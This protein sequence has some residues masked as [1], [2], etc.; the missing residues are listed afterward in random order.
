MFGIFRTLLALAVVVDHLGGVHGMGTYAVF[1]FYVLSGYL[2]TMVLHRTYGYSISGFSRYALNRWLRI[3]P[4]YYIAIG[5]SGVLVWLLGDEM[6]RQF[7]ANIGVPANAEELVRNLALILSINTETRLVAPAWAL[8][9]EGFFYILIGIGVSR[10]WIG[11]LVWLAFSVAYTGYLILGDA[12]WSYR[13]FTIS[14][15]SLPFALGVTVFHLKNRGGIGSSVL[16]SNSFLAVVVVAMCANYFAGTVISDEGGMG[17]HFYIN[18][19]MMAFLIIALGARRSIG[20]I[21]AAMDKKIGDLSYPVYLLHYQAGLIVSALT[22]WVRGE[23]SMLLA[24]VLVVVALSV[25]ANRFV[26]LPI[27]RL[28]SQLRP[29]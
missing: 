7:H 27:N 20:G 15:A 17:V 21:D 5:L 16:G 11:T 24:A 10:F 28:R 25:G 26:E 12:P 3:F 18:L 22:P 23:W 2:M 6:T 4:I 13:Y 8:T 29:A 14:A 1:G 9:V 19:L